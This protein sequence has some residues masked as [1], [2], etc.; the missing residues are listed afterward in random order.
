MKMELTKKEYDNESFTEFTETLQK[1][2]ED[3][4]GVKFGILQLNLFTGLKY[5][6]K[7]VNEKQ[8]N[9]DD[10]RLV[11]NYMINH[12]YV[13][14][15]LK[16][17]IQ[18]RELVENDLSSLPGQM[19]TATNS[20]ITAIEQNSSINVKEIIGQPYTETITIEK[21]MT[22]EEATQIMEHFEKNDYITKTGKIKDTMKNAL[23]SGTLDLPKKFE[24]TRDQFE[25]III[26]ADNKP[27]IRDASKE[28][29]VKLNK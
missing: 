22:Y 13:T 23:L 12:G 9:E 18:T 29:M 8:V 27:P 15:D 21:E 6:E 11:V 19:Q 20:I 5:E 14:Q 25:K 26:K 10:A 3:E 2:I 7:I 1:E 24:S 4:T 28:V 17:T 16:P